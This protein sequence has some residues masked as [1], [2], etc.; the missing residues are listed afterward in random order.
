MIVEPFAHDK[1]ENNL[2]PVGRVFYAAST[3]IC[4]PAS[5]AQEVGLCLGAQAGEGAHAQGGR[6]KADFTQFPAGY[7]DA[8]QF[9]CTKR[10]AVIDRGVYQILPSGIQVAGDIVDR[11]L[12]QQQDH[13]EESGDDEQLG[14]RAV[15]FDVHEEQDHQHHLEERRSRAPPRCSTRPDRFG[16]Q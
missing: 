16:R 6:R 1:L 9:E 4:T 11:D 8:V 2:N 10:R 13:P 3:M 15:G 7:R 12:A 5:R 14:E